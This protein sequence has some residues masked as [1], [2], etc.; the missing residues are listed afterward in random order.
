M[1]E[2]VCLVL[3]GFVAMS[4][5]ALMEKAYFDIAEGLIEVCSVIATTVFLSSSISA[6]TCVMRGLESWCL[7]PVSP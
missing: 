1:A 4:A 7:F 5:G 2:F 3:D 6:K